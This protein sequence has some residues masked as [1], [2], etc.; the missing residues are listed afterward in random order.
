MNYS[1]F[2]SLKNSFQNIFADV[3]LWDCPPTR[4]KL[5]RT[6]RHESLSELAAVQKSTSCF[7]SLGDIKPSPLQRRS[8]LRIEFYC[9]SGVRPAAAVGCT[10]TSARTPSL[11]LISSWSCG[12]WLGRLSPLHFTLSSE[13]WK[14]D[15]EPRRGMQNNSLYLNWGCEQIWRWYT[16]WCSVI[17]ALLH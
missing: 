10:N 12:M 7:G 3:S 4:T 8:T 16:C 14:S 11:F 13:R 15:A 5:T 2:N 9:G 1:Q 6:L 17:I